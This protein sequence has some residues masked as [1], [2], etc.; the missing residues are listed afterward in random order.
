MDSANSTGARSR[1]DHPGRIA[2]SYP[3]SAADRA[4]HESASYVRRPVSKSEQVDAAYV[5]LS[6]QRRAMVTAERAAAGVL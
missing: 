2:P 3:L 4:A 6:L 1:V 5:E